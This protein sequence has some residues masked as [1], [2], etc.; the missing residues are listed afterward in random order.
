MQINLSNDI[1]LFIGKI[2]RIYK[3]NQY[4]YHLT[5]YKLQKKISQ[6]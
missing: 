5:R 4:Q 6:Q 2:T 1:F 3:S